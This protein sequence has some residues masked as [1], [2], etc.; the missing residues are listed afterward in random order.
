MHMVIGGARL[1]RKVLQDVLLDGEIVLNNKPL[2][3]V[4]ENTQLPSLTPNMMLGTAN[5]LLEAES[6]RIQE[7]GL[8]KRAK[9]LVKCKE[10]YGRD[11]SL[12]ISHLLDSDTT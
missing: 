1:R 2:S 8:R 9:Y 3:Y 11:G 12:R 7:S 10:I 5:A 6:T 4:E